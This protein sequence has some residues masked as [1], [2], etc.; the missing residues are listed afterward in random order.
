[1]RDERTRLW[2]HHIR[3]PHKLGIAV[4]PCQTRHPLMFA[5]QPCPRFAFSGVCLP[6]GPGCT[7]VV[8]DPHQRLAWCCALGP[9]QFAEAMA[10]LAR[11]AAAAGPSTAAGGLGLGRAMGTGSRE[12]SQGR[13]MLRL[14]CQ[15][16]PLF[17]RGERN[18]GSARLSAAAMPAVPVHLA[19]FV[20]QR[21]G[22]ASA[23]RS[24]P[25]AS[26]AANS[27]S[28][29]INHQGPRQTALTHRCQHHR[30]AWHHRAPRSHCCRGR[31]RGWNRRWP[32][33]ELLHRCVHC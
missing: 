7:T 18:T 19:P 32:G 1:M 21:T 4:D 26:A 12:S 23:S 20:K 5:G 9:T 27:P 11:P 24:Q 22:R 31:G 33:G 25:V 16:L 29:F 3:Q 15:L 17:G 28:C 30:A 8:R 14:R 10:A 6:P 13:P 2:R